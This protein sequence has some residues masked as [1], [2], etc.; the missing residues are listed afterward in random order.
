MLCP[1][2]ERRASAR[3]AYDPG[4]PLIA[5][6]GSE[7]WPGCLRDVSAVGISL[8]LSRPLDVGSE[9]PIRLP[10]RGIACMRQLKVVHVT[11]VAAHCWVLGGRFTRA[12]SDEE[13]AAIV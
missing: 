2:V 3:V 12:L 13:L 10:T 6:V 1:A 9:V 11:R 4:R 7:S 8:L 5:S